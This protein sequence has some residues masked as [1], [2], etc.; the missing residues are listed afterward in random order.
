MNTTWA[1][2]SRS[3]FTEVEFRLP[4]LALHGAASSSTQWHG[5]S[6]YLRGSYH[7]VAPDL[8]AFASSDSA[9]SAIEAMV[10]EPV[11]LVGHLHGAALAL[12]IALERPE[13]VRSLTLI[14][15]TAFH[16]LRDGAPSDRALFAELVGLAN[17]MKIAV[18]AHDPA[19][20][21][22]AYVDFWYGRGAWQRTS[23]GLRQMLASHL[24]RTAADL[25]AS[26]VASW[27]AGGCARI[28]CPTL[29]VMA[30]ESP[31]VSL[32]V[33]EIVAET[34]PGARLAMIADAGHMAPLTDPHIVDPMIGAHLKAVDR[35]RR[36]RRP[37]HKASPRSPAT[38]LPAI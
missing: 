38:C 37:W 32:R 15:P 5:L 9:K 34:I 3:T 33:T 31:A 28:R 21:M 18:E 17:R 14:E 7:V 19:S 24:P 16:L 1:E 29:V 8:S 26:L 23:P 12:E 20:G 35:P 30:L 27:P 11:H 6:D 13:L 2:L 10:D 4:V 25:A 22:S 36:K